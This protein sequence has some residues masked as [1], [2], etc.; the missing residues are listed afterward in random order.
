MN[1]KLQKLLQEHHRLFKYKGQFAS[2]VENIM[3]EV[4]AKT[5]LNKTVVH[6]IISAQFR[7]VRDTISTS[8]DKGGLDT[9]DFD[10]YKS[11]RLIYL[12]AFMPSK[13]KFNKL[14]KRLKNKKNV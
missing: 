13:T 9:L 2:N 14:K 1:Q 8:S 3:N 10:N 6:Q 7:M 5:G 11:I 12:G 4:C